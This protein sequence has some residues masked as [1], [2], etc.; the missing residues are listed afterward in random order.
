MTRMYQVARYSGARRVRR[1]RSFFELSVPLRICGSSTNAENSRQNGNT[2][3]ADVKYV[4]YAKFYLPV[5][6]QRNT[7]VHTYIHSVLVRKRL[8]RTLRVQK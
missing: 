2:Y 7:Y 8:P 6:M 4:N 3:V 1:E 5:I